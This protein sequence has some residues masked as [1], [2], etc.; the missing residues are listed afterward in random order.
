MAQRRMFSKKIT[1]TDAFIDMPLSSQALYFHLNLGADD[2]GFVNKA[3]TIQ[4]TI[5]ANED[6][7]KIL[8]AK[9]FIIPFESGIV[10]I[11]HWRI[12]NY[13]QSD[14]FQSTLYKKEKEQLE[15]DETKTANLKPLKQYI[16]N[17]SKMETQVR[18]GKDRLDKGR[19][20]IY[21]PVSDE[22]RTALSAEIIDVVSYLN[23]K[24]GT[25]YKHS[26]QKTR[27]HIKARL[28]DGFSL[29]DF[30]TVINKKVDE[31]LNTD[32]SK[33]LRPETL[34]GTKFESYLNQPVKQQSKSNVPKWSNPNYKA[35]DLDDLKVNESE[36]KD[37]PNA[38]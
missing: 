37:D 21:S 8:I 31:W 20:D 32:M 2:E 6:D 29:E 1:E 5:G 4:R 17:V 19:L 12:H 18:L 34:F 30:K 33:Y 15:Y 24:A 16:Q 27:K 28:N 23:L 3:K 7:M 9:G 35:P 10:V 26:T 14:R 36:I 11:R 22:T 38:F 25:K 13:I